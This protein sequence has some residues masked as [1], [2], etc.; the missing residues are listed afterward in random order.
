[1]R[2]PSGGSSA[3]THSQRLAAAAAARSRTAA[4]LAF[5]AVALVLY[6]AVYGLPGRSSR[7]AATVSVSKAFV[8]CT[9]ERASNGVLLV[10]GLLSSGHIADLTVQA[11]DGSAA[12]HSGG[13]VVD[14]DISDQRLKAE[15]ASKAAELLQQ[16]GAKAL[17]ST[18][19]IPDVA[20][21]KSNLLRGDGKALCA[22]IAPRGV[23]VLAVV[24]NGPLTDE[25]RRQIAA[26]DV[27]LRFNEMN[28]RLECWPCGMSSLSSRDGS[29][30]ACCKH[31]E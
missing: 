10:S 6:L 3:Q 4:C 14:P 24:G 27:I 23:T 22:A 19:S 2:L 9:V 8:D 26:A 30:V 16:P 31:E 11:L 1:M 28:N 25:S 17:W 29:S 15:A 20:G 18:S 7:S 13:G 12:A 21:R 5:P